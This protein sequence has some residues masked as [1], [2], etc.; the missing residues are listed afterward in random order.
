VDNDVIKLAAE[1]S[2][3][4]GKWSA[5]YWFIGPEPGRAKREGDNLAARCAAWRE[6]CP[7]G[8]QSGDLIDC[9][10]HHEKIGRLDLF[11]PGPRKR[12][13]MQGT[14]R[15]LIRLLL[16]YEGRQ[17]DND[18]IAKCQATEWGRRDSDTCVIE[19]SALAMNSL[20]DAQALRDSF[21]A[22]RALKIREKAAQS[23]RL[24]FVIMYGGGRKLR[25]SWQ[26]IG[27][28]DECKN[29]F[30]TKM[31]ADPW[32]ADFVL[33]AGAVFVVAKHP[34]NPGGPAPP[35]EYWTGIAAEIRRLREVP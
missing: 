25:P 28:G 3:G 20:S 32:T 8:P 33:N 7:D 23:N 27:C 14:W 2:Y 24:Q 16:A 26:V 30:Q 35:A 4:Y 34:V 12:V 22:A 5:P 9:F 10:D 29:C 18:S 11:V 6:L 17:T 31:I 19:M 15:Q 1:Y 13:P 21:R